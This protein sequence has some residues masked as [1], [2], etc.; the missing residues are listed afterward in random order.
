MLNDIKIERAALSLIERRGILTAIRI[1]TSRAKELAEADEMNR[2]A[3]WRRIAARIAE[4][5]ER[6]G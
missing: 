1:A 3:V 5:T 4:R 2:V 6:R